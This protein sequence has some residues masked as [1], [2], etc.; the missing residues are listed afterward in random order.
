MRPCAFCFK[1]YDDCPPTRGESGSHDLSALLRLLE[2][3][4]VACP[5]TVVAHEIAGKG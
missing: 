3:P 2:V 4:R 5:F 1:I